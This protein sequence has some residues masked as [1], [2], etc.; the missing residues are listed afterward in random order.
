[1]CL[2]R[3]VPLTVFAEWNK[4]P[5]IEAEMQLFACC[6]SR[7]WAAVVCAARP[8][9]DESQLV[10]AAKDAWWSLK[11]D[12][13]LEAFACHPRIGEKSAEVNRTTAQFAAWSNEEQGSVSAEESVKLALIEL[14]RR[15][16]REYGF[17]YIVCASGKTQEEMLAILRARLGRALMVELREAAL[18][19]ERITEIRLRKWLQL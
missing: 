15:Y 13:W 18:Q 16:E 19:Q 8:Y 4:S 14:N 10:A 17:I 3:R 5:Q 2:V 7:R 6:G 1:M 11:E 9:A 12:D